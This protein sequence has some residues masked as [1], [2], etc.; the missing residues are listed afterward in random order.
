MT[1][2]IAVDFRAD[3]LIGDVLQA[4]AAAQLG[5]DA[6]PSG[7]E[8]LGGAAFGADRDFDLRTR[9]ERNT[10]DLDTA[11]VFDGGGCLVAVHIANPRDR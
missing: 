1:G 6:P 10:D 9:R 4:G 11:L 3:I 2:P 8:L 5:A 7:C